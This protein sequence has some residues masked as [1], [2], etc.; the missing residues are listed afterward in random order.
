MRLIT[1]IIKYGLE[2]F[3]RYYSEYRAF[4]YSVDDPTGN[5]KIQVIVPQISGNNPIG[6]WAVPVGNYS[7]N[8]YGVHCLPQVGDIV[9]VSFE[10]GD[11]KKKPVWR[12]G[13]YGSNEKPKEFSSK[14]T[15]GFKT[16]KGNI[17]IINEEEDF[18]R[19]MDKDGNKLEIS[20][21]NIILLYKNSK[22]ILEEDS[23]ETVS[24]KIYHGTKA[25][26]VH[27]VLLGDNTKNIIDNILS[28]NKSLEVDL[29]V[30]M[31]ALNT[32][33]SGALTPLIANSTD[34]LAKVNIDITKTPSTLSKDVFTK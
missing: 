30:M 33:A 26:A 34:R 31:N 17:F 1:K 3:N 15:F 21:K 2:Y 29:S 25:E 10:Y 4:V 18:I 5:D 32:V 6:N 16:P 8:G 12:H 28:R 14:N 23:K 22:I 24:D 7:G 19:L 9:W 13:Y 20:D 11:I 27:P